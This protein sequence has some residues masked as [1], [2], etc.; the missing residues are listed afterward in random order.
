MSA[1]VKSV[2]AVCDDLA[3][4][5]VAE[6]CA[7]AESY[8][9][10]AREAAWRGDCGLLRGHLLQ[11]RLCVITALDAQKRIGPFPKESRAHG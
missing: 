3:Y 5:A 11:L 6:T 10:S 4:D 9:V 1:P 7:L 8:A 2:Q